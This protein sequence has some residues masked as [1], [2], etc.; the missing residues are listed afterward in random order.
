MIPIYIVFFQQGQVVFVDDPHVNRPGIPFALEIA[1]HEPQVCFAAV[2]L[3]KTKDIAP[4]QIELNDG[5]HFF[6]VIRFRNA[7]ER[8]SVRDETAVKRAPMT[9]SLGKI[10]AEWDG[11]NAGQFPVHQLPHFV[12]RGDIDGR[13]LRPVHNLRF[14]H[15]FAVFRAADFT[16]SISAMSSSRGRYSPPH[17]SNTC[18]PSSSSTDS[19]IVI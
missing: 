2:I 16:S 11:L 13:F 5:R 9:A 10:V 6:R 3:S 18:M 8:G 12:A 1:Q 14:L 17:H 4:G 15:S 19:V 7:P